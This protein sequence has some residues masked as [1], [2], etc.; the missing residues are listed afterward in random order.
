MNKA[1]GPVVAEVFKEIHQEA[2]TEI[3]EIFE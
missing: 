2:K 1:L 3:I